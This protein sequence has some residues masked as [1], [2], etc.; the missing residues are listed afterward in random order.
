MD[1]WSGLDCV[2]TWGGDYLMSPD[3]YHEYTPTR[4]RPRARHMNDV[5]ECVTSGTTSHTRS[6]GC[7]GV[8]HRIDPARGETR[9]RAEAR[10][11]SRRR[12]P[13]GT[14][15]IQKRPRS[16]DRASRAIARS[17]ESNRD[18]DRRRDSIDR[19]M[20]SST[21]DVIVLDVLVDRS[22]RSRRRRRRVRSFIDRHPWRYGRIDAKGPRL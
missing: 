15:T 22:S 6:H 17:N 9:A 18:L 4:P 2:V 13:K 7:L 20:T 8:E 11:H 19:E 14:F 3:P 1:G 12:R 21:L 5:N 16:S 10:R